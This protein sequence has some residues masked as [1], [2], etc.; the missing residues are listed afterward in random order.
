MNYYMTNPLLFLREH[1][2]FELNIIN[3]FDVKIYNF[4]SLKEKCE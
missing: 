3:T 1:Y 4:S 2:R